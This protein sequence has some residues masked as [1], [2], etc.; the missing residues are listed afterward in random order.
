[1]WD[2]ALKLGDARQ[3]GTLS[4]ITPLASTSLLMLCRAALLPGA[5]DWPQP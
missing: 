4:Y 5:L 1:M 3:V 2:K